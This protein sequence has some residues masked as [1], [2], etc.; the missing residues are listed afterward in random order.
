MCRVSSRSYGFSATE[1]DLKN[2]SRGEKVF[3]CCVFFV[4]YDFTLEKFIAW[5]ELVEL[6]VW[7]FFWSWAYK[8]KTG[9]DLR[10]VGTKNVAYFVAL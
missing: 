2:D 9:N 3:S 8:H 10:I 6:L 1:S 5:Y 7:L 4:L